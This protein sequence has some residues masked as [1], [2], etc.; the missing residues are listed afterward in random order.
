VLNSQLWGELRLVVLRK[1]LQPVTL[2]L[3]GFP[4]CLLFPIIAFCRSD[5]LVYSMTDFELNV[6]GFTLA[7]SYVIPTATMPVKVPMKMLPWESVG[8]AKR[9]VVPTER[10]ARTFP[11]AASRA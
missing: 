9:E 10:V 4:T 2:S 7:D 11:V 5:V 1:G 6:Q 8:V 3:C